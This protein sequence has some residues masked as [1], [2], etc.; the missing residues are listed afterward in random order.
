MMRGL[1]DLFGNSGTGEGVQTQ[2]GQPRS[3]LVVVV[4]SSF[5]E[6]NLSNVRSF[7]RKWIPYSSIKADVGK[8]GST[9][10]IATNDLQSKLW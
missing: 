1:G 6:K 9:S 4:G 5:S 2:P 10:F 7:K 3:C 8:E